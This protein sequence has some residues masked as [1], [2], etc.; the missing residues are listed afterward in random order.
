MVIGRHLAAP[1]A[2]KLNQRHHLFEVHALVVKHR[3]DGQAWEWRCGLSC[4]QS[5]LSGNWQ[6]LLGSDIFVAEDCAHMR[7]STLGECAGVEVNV[8]TDRDDSGE[9]MSEAK[10]QR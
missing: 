9:T 6:M 1:G 8:W 7:H 4:H 5:D 2:P 10:S 3:L